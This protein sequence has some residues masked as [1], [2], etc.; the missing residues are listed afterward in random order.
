MR[1][2]GVRDYKKKKNSV[3]ASPVGHRARGR[4]QEGQ[5]AEMR[6]AL[7]FCFGYSTRYAATED[8]F[9]IIHNSRI[10]HFNNLKF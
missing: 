4:V 2:T 5:G 1:N 10:F 3:A 8:I 9:L 7:V 6:A